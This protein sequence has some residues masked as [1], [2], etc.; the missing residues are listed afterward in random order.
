MQRV[1]P[2]ETYQRGEGDVLER[3]RTRE[4]DDRREC[5]SVGK[6]I[7]SFVR[8]VI[9]LGCGAGR[10]SLCYGELRGGRS[11]PAPAGAAAATARRECTCAQ[12]LRAR[13]EQVLLQGMRWKQH[14][15]APTAEELL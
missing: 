11:H 12:S 1:G 4:G 8:H 7:S 9:G 6:Q 3:R 5:A 2:G 15:R 14:L 13:S 10:H